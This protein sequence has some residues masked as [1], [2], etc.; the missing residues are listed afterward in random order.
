MYW[1]G[2]YVYEMKRGKISNGS[3]GEKCVIVFMK[4]LC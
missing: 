4:F 2:D 3:A 1:P